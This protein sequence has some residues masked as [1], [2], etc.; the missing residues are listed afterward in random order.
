LEGRG[1]QGGEEEAGTRVSF[2]PRAVWVLIAIFAL[3]VGLFAAWTYLEWSIAEHVFSAKAGLDWFGITFYHGYTFI[4]GGILALLVI[5][6]KVGKSDLSG[7]VTLMS[8]RPSQY[9][10]EY[11]RPLTDIRPGAWVWGFWQFVKWALVF[12]FFVLNQSFPLSG[13]IMNSVAMLTQ[14]L[15]S[16]AQVPRLVVLPLFPA[17]GNDLISLMPTMEVQYKLV[18]YAATAF[19]TIF[20]L[21]MILRLL[22][23]LTTRASNVWIRNVLAI[24]AAIALSVALGA[25]YW[26]MDAATP[27]LFGVSIV[28][29]LSILSAYSYFGKRRAAVLPGRGIYRAVAVVIVLLLIVQAGALA[30]LFF[31]WNNNYISYQ[32]D[33][34]VQKQIT[35]TRWSAGIQKI[36][37]SSVL[38]LPTSNSSTILHVVRQWDQQA[39]AVTNTKE[40]GAYNWMALGSSEIVYLHNAEYWVSPTTPTYPATDWISEHLIYTHAAK[41]LVINTYNGSEIPVTKAYGVPTEPPIYYGEGEGFVNNVFVHV[42]GYDEIGN[43]SYTGAPDYNLTGWQ[44]GMWMTFAEGQLGFA[45]SGGPMQMLWN[46]NVFHRVQS[47]LIPGLVEDPAAYLATDG[48]SVYYVVQIYID[49]PMQSG[50]SKSDYLR[51][52]GVALVNVA[53]GSMNFYN[54]SNLVG[55][56]SSDFITNFYANYYNSWQAPPAWL[57]P[58]LRYPEQLLGSPFV[59]G[60]LDFDFAFHVN[61]PFVWRSGSQFYQRPGNN[62]VQYIPW[63]EGNGTYFVATQ[64][65]HYQNAASQ[66]LAGMYL[67]YGGDKL[68][69]IYLYQN[70]SNSTTIIGPSAAENALTTNQQ[71]RTQLTLLPNYRFG[72]Y[73]LYSV[74]GA[75]T[76]F[77]AVYTNPGTSGVVTQLPFM[78]AVNPI[79]DIVAVGAS[80]SAAYQNLLG[81]EAGT[82]TST[83]VSGNGGAPG[84]T[85]TTTTTVTTTSATTGITPANSQA[86]L[87]G[88]SQ[89]ATSSNLALVNATT[90]TPNVWINTG[91]ASLGTSGVNGALSQVSSLVQKYGPGSAGS[92]LYV[93]TDNTGALNVGIF[94]LKGG[95]TDLYYVTIR[96]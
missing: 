68:G 94:Q 28:V 31:N 54:V 59:S 49:Y 67:A 83:T 72:S 86:L 96:T 36:N 10:E 60:Q 50:F 35:V 45:F 12:G 80:A 61:D 26:Y 79:T 46:R 20:G 90:V 93:W 77:V 32:W 25:P 38:N 8:R 13:P 18:Y 81:L 47:V 95:V 37:A 52:F 22:K 51:F 87:A 14:G 91:S 71:V 48:K 65:V 78:T 16:W 74:G 44:K 23:N 24:G 1:A 89:L 15:G 2:G 92:A 56:G 29:L 4:V 6:P 58:Q 69:Q 88:I 75:L 85:T 82:T 17:S 34:G 53:D 57:V 55:T 30:F 43:A 41:I 73:L 5:N 21:R 64:L 66:N 76:Y 39:A 19:L 27:Y 70:P 42:P 11:A 33:P 40:I 63:A 62:T 7:L 84:T 9:G 3:I